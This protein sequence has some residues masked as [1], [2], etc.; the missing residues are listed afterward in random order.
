MKISE[1]ILDLYQNGS[2]STRMTRGECI[3]LD[4]YL[5]DAVKKFY[6]D[7]YDGTHYEFTFIEGQTFKTFQEQSDAGVTVCNRNGHLDT[8]GGS[9]VW[10]DIPNAQSLQLNGYRVNARDTIQEGCIYC[11]PEV[12]E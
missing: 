12:V 2:S 3:S 8:N 6:V 7:V 11:A 10:T 1:A 9:Y 5:H 4:A